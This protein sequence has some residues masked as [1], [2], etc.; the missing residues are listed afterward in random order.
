[1]R[2]RTMLYVLIAEGRTNAQSVSISPSPLTTR[3]VGTR[4]PLKSMVKTKNI[5]M[6]LR[7]GRFF[8]EST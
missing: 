8:N 7:P 1:M 5:V 3:Y 4:P 6:N 2:I